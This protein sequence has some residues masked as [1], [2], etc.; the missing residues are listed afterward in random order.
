MVISKI[1]TSVASFLLSAVLLLFACQ[2]T[3][4]T[5][6]DALIE[7]SRKSFTIL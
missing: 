7:R 4:K 6:R 5:I 2:L 3:K 1:K